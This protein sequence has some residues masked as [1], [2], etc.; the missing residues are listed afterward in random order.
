MD[1]DEKLLHVK[2]PLYLELLKRGAKN[3]RTW[4]QEA[5]IILQKAVE[6]EQA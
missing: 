5:K 6:A 2:Y 1:E 4:S 3:G